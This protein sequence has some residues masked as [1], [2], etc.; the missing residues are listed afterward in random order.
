MPSA[1]RFLSGADPSRLV[2]GALAPSQESNR[3]FNANRNGTQEAGHGNG[4]TQDYWIA[5][6]V[7]GMTSKP[8]SYAPGALD[9]VRVVDMT[10]VGM[11]PWATQILADMG[12]D[13][14]KIE[15]PGGGDVFR[16]VHPQ[17]HP[18]MSHAFLNLNRNKRSVV[19][20]AKRAPE[21]AALV[22]LIE[23]ADVF[24][25]NVRPQAL[26]RLNLDYPQLRERN[27]RLIYCGCY[28]YSEAGPYAGRPGVDDTIQAASSLAWF[29][30]GCGDGEGDA[31][32]RYVK[33]IIADKVAAMWVTQSIAMALYARERSGVGQAVEVP[34]FESLVAFMMIEHLAGRTFVPPHGPAGYNRITADSR[35]PFKTRDG[36]L[37]VVPYT[38]AQ[39]LRFFALAERPDIAAD[40]RFATFDARSRNIGELY[41]L[42]EP[43]MA[44]RT[45]AE[46]IAK[47]SDADLPF[48][49]VNSVDDLLVDPH[50]AAV[51]FWHA[52]EHPTE[53]AIT[54]PGIPVNYSATPGSI[55]RP[56]PTL[57]EHTAEVLAELGITL[58]EKESS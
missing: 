49:P 43:I 11:G 19:L 48:A 53:G 8:D 55:R 15:A 46:W 30:G 44:M 7:A 18:G 37:A 17:R 35:K 13:V 31:P 38:N 54:L 41:A 56:A 5:N 21:R 12:A 33:S 42:I 32:P 9:G 20:D 36:Y 52:M 1:S 50:L 10:A 28:A 26:A 4:G 14:I 23:R 16:H 51:G 27:P 58:T 6:R 39:W 45:S 24:V 3:L 47:L 2:A 22:A 34:M 40:A 25:S 57:G 29:Q